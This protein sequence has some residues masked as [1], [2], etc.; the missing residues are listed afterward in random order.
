MKFTSQELFKK[1]LANQ[2]PESFYAVIAKEDFQ[3]REGVESVKKLFN[4]SSEILT[5][6]GAS[7]TTLEL[8]S[9]LNEI[10]MFSTARLVVV[11][12][13]DALSKEGI[14]A[15]HDALLSPHP[16]RAILLS[17]SSITATSALYQLIDTSGV[18]LHLAEEKVWEKEKSA[19]LRVVQELERLKK[20][21]KPQTRKALIDAAGVDTATLVLELEKLSLFSGDAEEITYEVV[22]ELV[23]KTRSFDIFQLADALF[24]GRAKDVFTMAGRLI[25]EGELIALLRGLRNRTQTLL[26]VLDDPSPERRFPWMKGMILTKNREMAN[27]VGKRKLMRGLIA[28]DRA[29]LKAKD[30]DQ[31]SKLIFETLLAGMLP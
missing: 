19:D 24:E 18:Y 2:T 5:L 27:R 8:V 4:S 9:T 20:T 31:D 26:H 10:P 23:L 21:M 22:E 6:D 15:L 25:S 12:G 3:R 17:L 28:I 16:K 13:A 14:K 29:E 7:C 30:S 1:H 11:D